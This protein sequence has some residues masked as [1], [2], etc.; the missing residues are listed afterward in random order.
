MRPLKFVFPSFRRLNDMTRSPIR[1][2]IAGGGTAG[3]ITPGTAVVEAMRRRSMPHDILWIGVSGRAEEDLVPRADIPLR[4]L[5]LKGLERSLS[6]SGILRNAWTAIDWITMRPLLSARRL[7]REFRPDLVLGTGGYV[8]APVLT[9]ARLMNIPTLILEQNSVP[10]LTVR[11]LSRW[12]DRVGIAYP[13]SGCLLKGRSVSCVGNPISNSIVTA[14]RAEGIRMFNLDPARRTLLVIGGSLGSTVLND[15]V[16]GYLSLRGTDDHGWQILHSVGRNKFDA[17]M[18]RTPSFAEYHP[19]AYIYAPAL[20]LAAADLVLC[21]AGAM[22]LAELTARGVPAI[23]VPWPGAVRDHQTTNAKTLA[24]AGAAIMI[25]ESEL[26]GATLS[27]TITSF[28]SDSERLVRMAEA[29]RKLGNPRAA[30]D[31]LDIVLKMMNWTA[32]AADQ[33]DRS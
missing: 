9:A 17:Y 24:R 7:I 21:R 15:A 10:G 18:R 12:V 25:R 5:H 31:V 16:A 30:D 2:M 4:T 26:S 28:N 14:D 3:H 13:D 23:V 1:L 22:T 29:S 33:G 20:A 32:C 8:C 11:L 27:D 19:H 6:L